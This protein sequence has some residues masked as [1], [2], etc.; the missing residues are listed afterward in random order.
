MVVHEV[1]LCAPVNGDEKGTRLR[2]FLRKKH[3]GE[4]EERGFMGP[5][6]LAHRKLG[7]LLA[8][9]RNCGCPGAG[10]RHHSFIMS[11]T[12]LTRSRVTVCCPFS[13]PYY[14]SRIFLRCVLHWEIDGGTCVDDAERIV[15]R[16]TWVAQMEV[17]RFTPF[18]E[19]RPL[20]PGFSVDYGE[21]VGKGRKGGG[22]A[23]FSSSRVEPLLPLNQL[24][25]TC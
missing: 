4:V 6:P 21:I 10:L 17:G 23:V 5:S 25:D 22:L 3:V 12:I 16:S 2:L 8:T 1:A 13:P 24:P 11:R 9:S 18:R 7:D 19:G 20:V 14:G 15:R